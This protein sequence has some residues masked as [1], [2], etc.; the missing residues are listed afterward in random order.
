MAMRY[1]WGW[2]IGH[3]Y[4]YDKEDSEGDDDIFATPTQATHMDEDNEDQDNQDNIQP[5][6][7]DPGSVTDFLP[8]CHK[9][10]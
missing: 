3:I 9:R 5:E 6:E 8:T 1:Y 7:P 2:G 10:C 4:A